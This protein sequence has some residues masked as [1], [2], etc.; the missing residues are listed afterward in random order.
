MDD[1]GRELLNS[2]E[3]AAL[4]SPPAAPQPPEEELT[5]QTRRRTF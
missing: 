1:F 5:A 4:H 3:N 2:I